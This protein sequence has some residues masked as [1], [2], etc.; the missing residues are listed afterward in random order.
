[1]VADKETLPP[2]NQNRKPLCRPQLTLASSA[3]TWSHPAYGVGWER[4]RMENTSPGVCSEQLSNWPASPP[5]ANPDL[6]KEQKQRAVTGRSKEEGKGHTRISTPFRLVTTSLWPDG[7]E[8]RVRLRV[9]LSQR[10]DPPLSA[11]TGADEMLTPEIQEGFCTSL[12]LPWFPPL[13]VFS[14]P[15]IRCWGSPR[16]SFS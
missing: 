4:A 6:C 16:C 3:G 2:G 15:N 1:M 5:G 11:E 8:G 7:Q 13:S 12:R 9:Q 14:D 10:H